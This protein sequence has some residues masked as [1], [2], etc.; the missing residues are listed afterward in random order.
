[1][2]S[3]RLVPRTQVSPFQEI[4][5]RDEPVRHPF[6][7]IRDPSQG[8]QLV[9]LIE[10]VSPSNKRPGPDRDGYQARQAEVLASSAS[11]LEL[12]LH[13]TGRR[14]VPFREV[15][16]A[17][18][19]HEPPADYLVLLSRAWQR[20]PRRPRYHWLPVLL[21]E[22]LPVVPVPLREGEPE[23]ALDLQYVFTEA[24]DRG[25]YLRGAVD[26][27]GAPHVPVRPDQAAWLEDR[28][29]AAGLRPPQGADGPAGD[30]P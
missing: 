22:P 29:R 12:D 6:V 10:I 14:L 7:E 27:S 3:T 17:V 4:F 24:Y 28:L 23:P 20:Q 9:T 2:P 5:L 21:T 26:Y 16:A 18:L 25:P 11:L 13:R 1:M 8:H 19:Q 30:A 15:E